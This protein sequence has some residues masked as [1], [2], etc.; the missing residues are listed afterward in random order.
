MSRAV[1]KSKLSGG[2]V[3][4]AINIWAAAMVL[5]GAGI[6]NWNKGDFDKIDQKKQKLLN[7]HRV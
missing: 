4:N 5:Y 6:I 1:L 7:M 3:I 2:N